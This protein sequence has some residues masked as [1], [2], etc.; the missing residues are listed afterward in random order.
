MTNMQKKVNRMGVGT[1]GQIVKGIHNY[2]MLFHSPV[3][4]DS[5]FVGG[6]IQTADN[7]QLI[8]GA[9]GRQITGKILGVVIKD[10]YIT[11][12]SNTDNY[13]PNDIA[14]CLTKGVVYIETKTPAK[15]GQYVFLKNSDG[16]LA[17]DDTETKADHTYTGFR[18]VVGTG[19][20]VNTEVG[21]DIIAIM[22]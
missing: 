20:A 12:E 14:T 3:K 13:K 2:C 10:Q 9:S 19:S 11:A 1:A 8:Q 22:S 7:P 5:V 4:D 6:F 17:F 15:V 21:F 18:V 16:T